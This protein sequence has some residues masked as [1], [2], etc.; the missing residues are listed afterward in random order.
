MSAIYNRIKSMPLCTNE[1]E[2][3]I[4]LVALANHSRNINNLM[5]RHVNN[6]FTDAVTHRVY[7]I[8]DLL[9]SLDNKNLFNGTAK[10]HEKLEFIELCLSSEIV[11]QLVIPE[12]VLKSKDYNPEDLSKIKEIWPQILKL[13][14]PNM[15]SAM[16]QVFEHGL[17][18]TPRYNNIQV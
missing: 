4:K 14:N 6:L 1:T 12:P 11:D 8:L 17:P 3:Y 7:Q 18:H 13:V 9:E 15:L 2:L 16:K 10:P 5:M